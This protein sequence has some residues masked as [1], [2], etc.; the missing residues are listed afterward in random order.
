MNKQNQIKRTLA[1]PAAVE[2]IRATL[3]SQEI[4]NRTQLAVRLCE[5][6]DLRDP[7]GRPQ[8]AGCLRALRELE[9]EGRFELP[10]RQGVLR[11]VW[12]PRR[13]SDAV[14][15]PKGV[16]E[17]AE[18]VR[19]L[20]LVAVETE[21]HMRVW[22][23]LMARDHPRGAGPLV[24]RQLRYLIDSEHGWLGGLGFASAALKLKDRDTWIG[25]DEST[26]G[27]HLHRVVGMSRF[28]IRSEVRCRNL[29]SK[30]LGMVQRRFADDFEAKYG[31]RP[32]LLESFVETE[33]HTGACYRAANWLPVGRT[34]G[35]GRQDRYTKREETVKAVYVYPLDAD[36]R[37]E[38]GVA[39]PAGPASLDPAEGMDGPQWADHEFGGARLGDT[40]WS[41]RL[42]D[43]ARAQAEKPGCAFT[44]AAGGDRATVK[45]YYRMIDQADDSAVT[46]EAMLAPHRERTV[47]R[48]M[49]QSTVLC[50]QDGTDLN[51][52]GLTQ[53]KGLGTIGTNQ[54]TSKT[55]GLHL[56]STFAV[57]TDGTPLGLLKAQIE[58]PQPRP[59]EDKRKPS[60]IPIEEK[61]SY[62]WIKGVRDCMGLAERLPQTRQVCVMDREA[63]FYE[64][65]DEQRTNSCV[66]LL[67]RAQYDRNTTESV[68]L[69]ESLRNSPV[70]SRLRIKVKRQ[71]AR[72]KRSK[73]KAK[74]AR[75][76][77]TAQVTLHYRR[78][79]FSAPRRCKGKAPVSLWAVYVVEVDPP[80]G[81]DPVEWCL[82]TTCD[83][84]SAEDAETCLRWYCLRW[85]I[86]DWHRVLKSG[87]A[88][89]K[90]AYETAE[91]LKRGIAIR[92]VI[93]WRIM[94]MTLL[95]RECPDLPAEVLFSDLE[96]EVLTAYAE[97]KR[98]PVPT[99]L[100]D[101]VRLTARIGGY[102]DRP[103]D[104]PPGHQIMWRGLAE[105]H[106]M[107]EGYSLR[108]E[109]SG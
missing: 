60:E 3:D 33:S 36:F 50:I 4:P 22:N 70:H 74:P 9:K 20:T 99:R 49:G 35:R 17:Q 34:A 28:L 30:V 15:A 78:V 81:V 2:V 5:H 90:L 63:D 76:A 21:E 56:H 77:R 79:E 93:A 87:C 80:E 73:Q 92:A 42:V 88:V 64:L 58:A 14:E 61:T 19:G 12:N 48:M 104:P 6:F 41:R 31:I 82:L 11:S 101:A 97:K 16:P 32:W 46:P 26:R 95:G 44:A 13:L 69:F 25:W 24:G 27:D 102:L 106:L 18:E 86:E 7:R 1:Q 38:M 23:E 62:R 29:A 71:S 96:I 108:K 103:S 54:T 75:A 67:V 10:K 94:L 105:L 59:P 109:L 57:A 68:K 43:S 83:I 45:G 51:Y 37:A 52:S 84:A 47:R 53:C 98:F 100:G 85:R 8:Q 40:R 107:C 89:E 72:P 39:E 91:R 55:R 65:F 66:D